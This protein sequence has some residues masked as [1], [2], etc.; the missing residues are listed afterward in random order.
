MGDNDR[1]VLRLN[2]RARTLMRA[3][4]EKE[5]VVIPGATHLFEEHGALE[6]VAE[7]ATAWFARWLTEAGRCGNGQRKA[8]RQQI[9]EQEAKRVE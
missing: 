1:D 3:C 6:Q 4:V 9:G 7:A 2:E 8:E 5:L